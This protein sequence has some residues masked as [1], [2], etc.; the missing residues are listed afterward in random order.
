[1]YPLAPLCLALAFL[2]GCT[3]GPKYQRPPMPAP[4]DYKETGNWQ[5]ANPGDQTPKGKWWEI[6][7]DTQLNAL[8]EQINV[9]NQT[10]QASRQQF[11]QARSL[12]KYN[13]ADYYPTVTAGPSA[14]RVGT[15]SHRPALAGAGATY[16]DF[17]IPVDVAYEPDLWGRVRRTVEES[18]ENAQ[19][20]FG[21]LENISLSLHAELASDYFQLRGLDA[22]AQLLNSTAEDYKQALELTLNRYHGGVASEVDVAQAQTQLKTTQAQALDVGVARAQY[23]HAIAVLIGKSPA[24]FGLPPNP[25][26]IPPPLIPPGL[27]S[28]LLERRPD[29]ASAERRMAAANAQIGVAKSAYYPILSLVGSGGFESA[30]LGTLVNGPSGFWSVGG[31]LTQ[32]LFEG[33]RRRSLSQQAREAYD[34]NVALYRQTVLTAFQEV[35]DNLAAQRILSEESQTQA[36]AVT[37]SQQSLAL[38]N[39]RYKGGV[40]TYLEVLTAQSTALTD[41]RTAVQILER[42]MAAGVLLIKALGGGWNVSDMPGLNAIDTASPAGSN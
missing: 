30:A 38:S 24:E 42:R 35:E 33:G 1:V 20:S 17:V 32:T 34:Q 14:S 29:V 2:A 21:D 12:I 18:R 6:F 4:P 31:A 23:E 11:L 5:P 22:E 9:S 25:L 36:E 41:E 26:K 7:G 27:P 39:N 19:A 3:V 8:E 40:T 13:R 28:Q 10:L 15:S 37:A 16:N